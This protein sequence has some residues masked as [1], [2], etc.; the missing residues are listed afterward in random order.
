MRHVINSNGLFDIQSDKAAYGRNC[1][2]I[3]SV[4]IELHNPGLTTFIY[5]INFFFR[6][7]ICVHF[8]KIYNNNNNNKQEDRKSFD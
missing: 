7:A 5:F 6:F 4:R 2:K 3:D 8:F 1:L